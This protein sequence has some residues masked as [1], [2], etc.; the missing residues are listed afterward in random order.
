MKCTW[1][2]KKIICDKLMKVSIVEVVR[3]KG[4]SKTRKELLCDMKMYRHLLLKSYIS[5]TFSDK[6]TIRV[7]VKLI[8][9][10]RK[11]S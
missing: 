6:S 7:I 8:F 9:C 3:I 10:T 4:Q 5:M 1:N 2:L 11:T